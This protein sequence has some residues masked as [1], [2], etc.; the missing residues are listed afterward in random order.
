MTADVFR[1]SEAPFEPY[2]GP[3]GR[4]DVADVVTVGNSSTIAAGY[5]ETE[6]GPFAYRCDYEAVCVPLDDAMTWDTGTGEAATK[7]GDVIW[8]PNGGRASYRSRGVSRFVY[9]TFPVNWP[10]IVG[11]VAGQDIKDFSMLDDIGELD[12]VGLARAGSE[13]EPWQSSP[14]AEGFQHAILTRPRGG[15]AMTTLA[16]RTSQATT[17]SLG[18]GEGLLVV[19]EGDVMTRASDDVKQGLGAGDLLWKHAAGVLQLKT[20]GAARMLSISAAD[21]HATAAAH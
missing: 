1:L 4:V 21:E 9:A 16:L 11:W 13:T 15:A 7:P 18:P 6:G 3:P 17:W 8:I 10:E 5:V 20:W 12:A 19:L 2:A 14:R